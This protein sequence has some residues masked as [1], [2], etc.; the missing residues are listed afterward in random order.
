[1][2]IVEGQGWPDMVM[3]DS[4]TEDEFMKNLALRFKQKQIYTFIGE[5]I[6]SMNPF[7]RMN[8]TGK[9]VIAEYRNKYMY[10]VQPH[11]FALAEDTFRQLQQSKKDQCV[12]ITGE[13]GA[14]KTEA[15]KIFMTYI[16]AITGKTQQAD[17]IKDRLLSSN[18]VLEAFGNAKTLRNDNSSRFGKY[19]EIQFDGNVVPLGG[20]I[21]QYLLEKS[22]V[23][24]R[25]LDERS[26]HIFY[27]VLSQQKIMGGLGLSADPSAYYYLKLSNC[28]KVDHFDDNAEFQEVDKGLNGLGFNPK[29]KES[30]WKFIGAILALGNIEFA[31]VKSQDAYSQVSNAD[32]LAKV[33]K[34]LQVDPKSLAKAL[35]SR[36]IQ[37]GGFGGGSDIDVP[38][39]PKQAAFARDSLGKAL[40]SRIFDWVVTVINGSIQ[41]TGRPEMSTGVLDIYGFEIFQVNSFEQFCINYCNEKLQQLFIELVLQTE[42]KVYIE[43]GIKWTKIDYFDNAPILD[44]V[45]GKQGVFK[46]LDD[47]CMVGEPT[48]NDFL[49]KL[50]R[51]F[52]KNAHYRSFGGTKTK[53]V[54]RNAF[55]VIHYAGEVDYCIDEFL[56]K[57]Q[58]TLYDSLQTCLQTSADP[59]MKLLFPPVGK[60]R[61]RP[62][63][64]GTG[65]SKSVT[66]LVETLKKC[67]PHYIRCIKSNDKKQGFVLDEQRVK[68]QCAYL[69][70]VE[71]V[72]VRKAGFAARRHYTL[73]LARYKMISPNTWPIWR[74]SDKDGVQQIFNA[75]NIDMTQYQM[76]KTQ[77]FV[78][79]AKLLYEIEKRRV[80]LLPQV[81]VK[82]Q[83]AYRGWQGRRRVKQ[84]KAMK[85]Q[86]M[87]ANKIEFA[88][89]RYRLRK[90]WNEQRKAYDQCKQNNFGKDMKFVPPPLALLKKA[91]D[92]LVKMHRCWWARNKVR[93]LNEDAK[94]RMRL[95]I[96]AYGFFHGQKAW[97][98]GRQWQGDYCNVSKNPGKEEYKL[99]VQTLFSAGGDKKILFSDTVIKVNKKAKQQY[100]ALILTDFNIYKYE[101][102][103]FKMKKQAI[104]LAGVQSINMSHEHDSYVVIKMAPPE[105]DMVLDL[106]VNGIEMASEFVTV[107]HMRLVEMGKQCPVN[108]SE[109]VV[110]NNNRTSKAPGKEWT[111]TFQKGG[112]EATRRL[113]DLQAGG[114]PVA[115]EVSKF[116]KISE[117]AYQIV[118]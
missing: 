4:V 12:I 115:V 47:V 75:M 53:E 1:M 107:L 43:E 79:D 13:S 54:A 60:S 92:I 28:F 18:P 20:R 59:L 94:V 85:H 71:T 117:T 10:E 113:T 33:A 86:R 51:A 58:D 93:T 40:Y 56:F 100:R 74:G 50:D 72:R 9:E 44:L 31:E 42:Q 39:Y 68:H 49:D 77:V 81:V 2:N 109:S 95:K 80:Q 118:G 41:A 45:E 110:F 63:T 106:R 46:T 3:I 34:L 90:Y 103:K 17:L 66:E 38:L 62:V 116:E 55:R 5:Q 48:P 30:V 78:K 83:A 25:A 104:P 8:N 19:M 99:A 105:R 89:V 102:K 67:M 24:T 16:S 15:S 26:F 27:L 87:Y 7:Q 96:V 91:P 37:T 111:L 64:A 11:I 22:R 6:V 36:S 114:Q 82:L 21:S 57:N 108:F 65:F 97:S 70:L 73:F 112:K 84:I 32:Q 101:P 98:V 23:V 29:D 52:N 69:N 88:F 14:G 61:K 76:G 35:V